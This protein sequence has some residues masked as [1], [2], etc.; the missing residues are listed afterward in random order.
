MEKALGIGGMFFRA[1]NPAA[2]SQWYQV[3]LGITPTPSS[4]EQQPWQ[5]EAGPT[6][7][8]PFPADAKY[9]GRAEPRSH[10]ASVAWSDACAAAEGIGRATDSRRRRSE[11]FSC[12]GE[13]N[14][15]G[16]VARVVHGGAGICWRLN[17]ERES[18]GHSKA[19][20]Q[21]SDF[22]DERARGFAPNVLR[23]GDR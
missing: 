16:A 13:A 2:L 23:R 18:Y 8:A 5:Q 9:F 3:H 19:P 11:S 22:G 17:H 1:N 21:R 7:F 15:P 6:V 12:K 4:Y 20:I 10:Q 14:K